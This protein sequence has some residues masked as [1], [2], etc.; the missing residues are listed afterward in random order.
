MLEELR[1]Y[2]AF[3]TLAVCCLLL[4][5]AWLCLRKLVEIND[6]GILYLANSLERADARHREQLERYI[7]VVDDRLDRIEGQTGYGAKSMH[8]LAAHFMPRLRTKADVQDEHDHT[9]E[10]GYDMDVE[11]VFRREL[12]ERRNAPNEVPK[13][14]SEISV[15]PPTNSSDG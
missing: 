7:K 11:S 8:A 4:F 6:V 13:G 15:K 12:E 1:P 5:V 14:W 2:F 3:A 10:A 9:E